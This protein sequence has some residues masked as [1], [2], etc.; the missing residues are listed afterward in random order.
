MTQQEINNF[1]A[2]DVILGAILLIVLV[3]YGVYK[4]VD[5]IIFCHRLKENE[6]DTFEKE[7]IF[8]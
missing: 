6:K 5:Y 7:D 3:L 4:L 8:K 1:V 2:W